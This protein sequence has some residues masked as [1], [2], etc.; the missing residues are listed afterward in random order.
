LTATDTL[1]AKLAQDYDTIRQREYDLTTEFLDVLPKIDNIA[2]ENVA[3]VRDALFHTDHPFLMVLVGPFSSGKSSLINALLGA[4]DLLK[5]GPVP[6]TDRIQI[7]RWGDE[8]Q[9]MTSASDVDTAFYPSPLLRKVSL[10]DTPGLESVLQHHEEITKKFLHRSDVVVLVMLAT[11]AMT[12]SNLEYL[13]DFKRYGKKVILLI[14]QID[15]L[16]DDERETVRDY[17]ASQSRTK[18]G[19]EPVIWMASAKWGK[20]ARHN[21]T[22]DEELWHK[23]GLGQIENYIETQLGDTDR[24]RQK[25]QTPLQIVQNAHTSALEIVKRNQTTFD[26]Y[27]SINDNLEQQLDAQK[28]ELEK[29]VRDANNEVEQRFNQSIERS[30]DALRDIFQLTKALGSLG[31]GLL[32]LVGI[33]RFLRRGGQPSPVKVTFDR[34]KVHEPIHEITGLVDKVAPRL[35]G[36]DM[37]DLDNLVNYGQKELKA[38]PVSMQDKMIGQIQAPKTYDRQALKDIRSQL[39]DLQDEALKVETEAVETARRDTL[40]YLAIWQMLM[41]VFLIALGNVWSALGN[42]DGVAPVVL[43]VLILTASLLGFALLPLRGRMIHTRYANR[44]LKLN[45]RH[46][47]LLTQACDQQIEYSMKLRRDAI[48]PLTRLVT[49]QANIHDEQLK[50]LKKAERDI[51]TIETSLNALGKRRVLGMTF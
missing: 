45:N 9:T 12:Q 33:A 17:V 26:Q 3:Q 28:R 16:S 22:L 42:S 25:L 5:I 35:E 34:F 19:F 24:L 38:L 14:N 51:Q 27:R 30:R 13:Q 43:L 44:L 11:Q 18:L 7:L 31:R 41:V 29:L 15:L 8:P 6:T 21:N 32:E 1:D 48:A 47:E 40:I 36:Q 50:F 49:S 20:E 4:D 10:V 2:P 23:S 37:Q 39:D 46:A